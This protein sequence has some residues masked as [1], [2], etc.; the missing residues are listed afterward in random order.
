MAQLLRK[1]KA[2]PWFFDA[3]KWRDIDS[4]FGAEYNVVGFAWTLSED[5]SE[6]IFFLIFTVYKSRQDFCLELSFCSK[7]ALKSVAPTHVFL[8]TV[9]VGV[10]AERVF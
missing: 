3:R 6:T 4:I 5:S 8:L 10:K 7:F 1:S 2:E 9:G